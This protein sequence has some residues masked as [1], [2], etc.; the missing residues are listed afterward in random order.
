MG[1]EWATATNL[2]SHRVCNLLLVKDYIV[3]TII[4]LK[5]TPVQATTRGIISINSGFIINMSE[6]LDQVNTK[7]TSLSVEESMIILQETPP[8]VGIQEVSTEIIPPENE[9]QVLLTESEIKKEPISEDDPEWNDYKIYNINHELDTN[10]V[11]W[12]YSLLRLFETEDRENL[13]ELPHYVPKRYSARK[14]KRRCLSVPRYM[15]LLTEPKIPTGAITMFDTDSESDNDGDS[16]NK[17]KTNLKRKRDS[18]VLESII[19]IAA[20]Q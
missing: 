3:I 7:N 11:P 4:H 19:K 17:L 13:N 12:S 5:D 15:K 2:I 20:K 18:M 6:E 14:P 16:S 8:S 9:Q 10:P 1:A